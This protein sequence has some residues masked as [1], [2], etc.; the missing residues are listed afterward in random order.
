MAENS[1][2]ERVTVLEVRVN[3]IVA[4]IE[5]EKGTRAR[6]NAEHD[7]RL[8]AV[9]RAMYVGIGAIALLQIGLGVFLAL[10]KSQ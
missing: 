6:A 10:L 3:R 5:S 2:H 1:I 7:V 4:D 9:E 8:R